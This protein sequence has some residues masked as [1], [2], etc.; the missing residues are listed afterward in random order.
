MSSHGGAGALRTIAENLWVTDGTIQMPPGPLP[1]RMSIARLAN[2]ELVVFSA[3]ALDDAG[4]VEVEQL[5][6]PSFLVVPNGFHRQ[7]APVWKARYP[8]MRVVAPPGARSAVEE[9]VPVDDSTGE[10][11]DPSVRFVAVAGTKGESALVVQHRAGAT[12]VV[13]DLIGNV[14]HARG[15]MR[16]ILT[17]M[18]FSGRRPQVPRA[19]RARAID[20][21]GL[22]AQQF[23][24]WADLPQ[25]QRIIMSHG[26]IID[27]A[28]AEVLRRLADTLAPR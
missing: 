16:L 10:F 15:L 20:D 5:G 8:G 24:Q 27:T 18:G 12:V 25:L 26:T 11:G 7:D 22:V 14:Q 21:A 13:N 6:R 2:G 17:L 28:P 19:Y 4:F 1:R 3:I 23:R 9:V